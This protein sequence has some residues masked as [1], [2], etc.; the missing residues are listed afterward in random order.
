MA[1]HAAPPIEPKKI[2]E[3]YYN[4]YN[5]AKYEEALNELNKIDRNDTSY[6]VALLEKAVTN[7]NLERYD[8]AMKLC[9]EGLTFPNR[10]KSKFYVNLSV[11]YRKNKQYEKAL[12]II[13]EASQKYPKNH[14]LSYNKALTYVAMGKYD[15]AVEQLKQTIKLSPLYSYPHYDL[16]IIAANEGKI[17]QAMLCFNMFLTLEPLGNKAFMTLKTFNEMV[18]SKYEHSP[19]NI[20]ID[21]D[22]TNDFSEIDIIIT[23]YAALSKNFKVPVKTDLNLIKQNYALF[24]KMNYDPDDKGFWMQTYVK[25]FKEIYNQKQFEAYSYYILQSSQNEQH[26]KLVAQN[27]AKIDKFVLWAVNPIKDIQ[28]LQ[29]TTLDNKKGIYKHWFYDKTYSTY[30]ISTPP[31]A[32]APEKTTGYCEYYYKSGAL[33][34]K[35]IHDEDAQRHGTWYFYHDDGTLE[36]IENYEH[37]KL[38]G[39]AQYYN[40]SGILV[41]EAHYKDGKIDGYKNTYYPSGTLKSRLHLKNGMWDGMQYEYYPLGENFLKTKVAYVNGEVKD[42]IYYYHENGTLKQIKVFSDK[43]LNGSCKIF[44]PNGNLNKSFSYVNDMLH[45]KYYEYYMDGKLATEG[46]YSE[47]KEIGKWITYYE[48]GGLKYITSF[49]NKGKR[50]GTATE[51]DTDGIKLS[52]TDYVDGVIVG[53]RFYDKKG[54]VI[55]QSKKQKG[56]FEFV[57]YNTNQ[58][59]SFEGTYVGNTKKGLWKYYDFFGTLISEENYD[60]EGKLQ[61]FEKVY[62]KSGALK[63]VTNYKDNEP[64]GKYTTYYPNGKIKHEGWLVNGKLEG[65]QYEY[66][67]DGTLKE[68]S[69]YLN[70]ELHGYTEFYSVNGKLE[71]EELYENGII[72]KEIHYDT[73]GA[74]S[75]TIELPNGT[76]NRVTRYPNGKPKHS[77]TY[78]EGLLHGKS[79]YYAYNGNLI[80]EGQYFF[81]NRHGDWVWYH[82][83]KNIE[84]KG[85]YFYGDKHG[86]WTYYYEDGK[87]R[88]KEMY[89]YGKSHGEWIWYYP[90][91]NIELK[92]TFVNDNEEGEAYYYAEFGE[93]QFKRFYKN[94]EVIWYAYETPSGAFTEPI[95]V[96]SGNYTFTAYYKNGQKSREYTFVNGEFS[97]IDTKWY[98]NG[99]VYEVQKFLNNELFDVCKTYYPNG[100]LKEEEYYTYDGIL[101]RMCYYYY[102]NGNLKKQIPYKMGYI[103]GTVIS[104][105]QNRN[106]TKKQI[107]FSGNLISETVY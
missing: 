20:A 103:H 57:A 18:S 84:T 66:Y 19:K 26:K 32:N 87:L 62:Y 7:I 31:P 13:E 2:Y 65:Y 49:D 51:Y 76:G 97:G 9:L 99:Q 64:N 23:N 67:I 78:I 5:E 54:Q 101:D 52:E 74:I 4:Y 53:Y 41:F 38:N 44:Y 69:Y 106:I 11:C 75:Y 15:L 42:T 68:K 10:Y 6:A 39:I 60:K 88:R 96:S 35:G 73:T 36:G 1:Q 93:L 105:D 46:E 3:Q 91:G 48:H 47:D 70:N 102:P 24:S 89:K 17:A 21:P 33:M 43:K 37:G 92:K 22:A 58:K 55:S 79:T 28:A 100:Y 27:K 14:L 81:N 8:E 29:E 50:N 34:S 45:G 16:G 71:R 98:P 86:E 107:Y 77:L 80:S 56:E 25:F 59:K 40:S 72:Q 30:F 104:Y 61:G 85:T 90:N 12:S 95:D 94:G 63:S 83:N 82:D